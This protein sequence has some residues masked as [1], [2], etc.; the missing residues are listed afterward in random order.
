MTLDGIINIGTKTHGFFSEAKNLQ[1]K[2]FRVY[3]L[4]IYKETHYIEFRNSSV[5]KQNTFCFLSLRKDK[6][7]SYFYLVRTVSKAE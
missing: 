2:I 7:Y 1:L 3:P 6:K 5:K 4:Y